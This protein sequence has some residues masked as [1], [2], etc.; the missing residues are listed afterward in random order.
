MSLKNKY[1]VMPIVGQEKNYSCGC[2]C[3]N[4]LLEFYGETKYPEA[5]LCD[6][7]DATP[8][9]GTSYKSIAAF[10][11][12]EGY[13]V[14]FK[15]ELTLEDLKRFLDNEHPVLVALQAWSE[16]KNVDYADKWNSG[17]YLLLIGYNAKNFYFMD[18]SMVGKYGYI[19]IE[20]FFERFHDTDGE[21]DEVL[22]QFGMLIMGPKTNVETKTIRHKEFGKIK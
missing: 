9:Y 4:A 5:E 15:Q 14:F 11:K 3:V 21:D 13:H 10:F 2:A 22:N 7:I 1:L 20:E 19:P 18:P 8:A 16:Q 17:H 12:K 6:L